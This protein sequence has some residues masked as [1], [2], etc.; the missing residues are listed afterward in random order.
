M[1]DKI[2]PSMQKTKVSSTIQRH[3]NILTSFL[4]FTLFITIMLSGCSSDKI[5]EN[6]DAID[7]TETSVTQQTEIAYTSHL[8]NDT[9]FT[10]DANT[11]IP[12]TEEPDKITSSDDTLATAHSHEYSFTTV[13]SSCTEQGYT[14]YKCLQCGDTYTDGYTAETGHE[15]AV[16]ETSD[17][18]CNEQGR[19]VYKCNSCE[20]TKEEY[21]PSLPHSYKSYVT[22]A[23]CTND[24]YTTHT[25]EKCLHSFTDSITKAKGH[26]YKKAVI[27]ATCT[28]GG[29]TSYSCNCGYAY[30]DSL[31]SAKGHTFGEWITVKEP[32]EQSDGK[33]ERKCKL[34]TQKESK[35]LNKL[36]PQHTHKYTS[37]IQKS[38]TCT[39]NGILQYK[40]TCGASYTESIKALSHSY[41]NTLTAP[42]CTDQGYTTHTCSKCGNS[43]KDTYTNAKGHSYGTPV[44]IAPTCTKDGYTVHKCKICTYSYTDGFVTAHH[45]Y[46]DVVTKATC[47]EDGYTTHKCTKCSYSYTDTTV[48]ASGHSYSHKV[49]SA[50]CL[51]KGYTTHTCSKCGNSYKDTYTDAKGHSYYLIDRTLSTCVTE[52]KSTYRCTRCARTYTEAIPLSNHS[53]QYAMVSATCTEKG[54][55]KYTC[56]VCGDSYTDNEWDA[57]G[58]KYAFVSENNGTIT[59]GC[60]RCNNSSYKE[61]ENARYDASLTPPKVIYTYAQ[62]ISIVS[63]CDS[64]FSKNDGYMCQGIVSKN[65]DF[66]KDTDIELCAYSSYE[67]YYRMCFTDRTDTNYYKLRMCKMDGDVFVYGP[68]TDIVEC[69]VYSFYKETNEKPK[70]TY[71]LYSI[72]GNDKVYAGVEKLLFLKTDNPHPDSFMLYTGDGQPSDIF[73]SM[74]VY[75]NPLCSDVEYLNVIDDSQ[76]VRKVKGGYL[77]KFSEDDVGTFHFGL[78]EA[79]TKGYIKIR[80][81]DINV[82]D[83][84]KAELEWIDDAIAKSTNSQMTSKEKLEAVIDYIKSCNFRYLTN[85][86]GTKLIR[87]ARQ[88]NDPWFLSYRW[89]SMTSPA[90]LAKIAERIGGFEK[91]VNCYTSNEHDWS[92]H[93]MACVTY[94][95]KEYY[96]TVCP[97]AETGAANENDLKKIDF[98]SR[99]ELSRFYKI[100]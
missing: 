33:A 67:Y 19:T 27:E 28:D 88:P 10:E 100:P 98:T 22:D 6:T 58:H 56:K 50:T 47:T 35:V 97:L 12:Q 52:G 42:T 13:P 92:Y 70:Y 46:T 85:R 2:T 91:V 78:C 83:L 62:N 64:Q 45:K 14:E 99:A 79:T 51:E 37:N 94:N 89:D 34:C 96:Y 17:P 82:L 5:S 16:F 23:T 25:C 66:T 38:P 84:E 81:Y 20:Y 75:R 41:Q 93:H 40:C 48:K 9:S 30:T 1:P 95:G 26:T 44:T 90:V 63:Y 8:Q 72:D 69:D 32:T 80:T 76:N 49:T 18:T 65:S 74:T 73:N 71:E 11:D 15:L 87:L 24:G 31:T 59:Y 57:L 3:R 39:E 68:W 21:S 43:Y 61:Y 77:L 54:C 86:D 55:I 7:K 53:Y 4:L 60:E 29:Y 36:I